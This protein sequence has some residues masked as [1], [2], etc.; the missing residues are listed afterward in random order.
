MCE[1]AGD[2]TNGDRAD[3]HRIVTLLLT[4]VNAQLG[5]HAADVLLYD[6]AAQSFQ[7]AGGRGFH[8][9]AFECSSQRVTLAAQIVREGR[10]VRTADLRKMKNEWAHSRELI[11]EGM[12]AYVGVPLVANNQ[13]CGVLEIFHREHLNPNSVWFETMQDIAEHGATALATAL[14]LK[15]LKRSNAELAEAYDAL[16]D[17]WA[18]ALELRD[19]EPK[20]HTRRVTELTVDFA[21]VMGVAESELVHIRRGAMLHD[22]GKMGIPDNILLKAHAL[23]EA[24]WEIM[25]QHPVIAYEQLSKIESLRPALVI[26]YCHHEKWDG[27][28]YPRGLVGE[29]IPYIARLFA[30]VDVWDSLRSDRPFRKGWP[31]DKVLEHIRDRGGKHFDPKL[32][33]IFVKFLENGDAWRKR[34]GGA[35][36]ETVRNYHEVNFKI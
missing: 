24:E 29:Q 18:S 2:L 25:R 10:L 34:K 3:L 12:V 4:Q 7:Y 21:R 6:S 19:Y 15:S 36:V 33:D 17:G 27:T 13:L 20:E 14:V 30:L 11:D 31:E 5:V 22:M 26:P 8:T 28:G 23:D 16:I 32:A 35:S 9:R 1:F